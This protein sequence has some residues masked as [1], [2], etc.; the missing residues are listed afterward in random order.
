MRQK[1]YVWAISS[2]NGQAKIRNFYDTI[3]GFLTKA[4][5]N[6]QPASQEIIQR[7]FNEIFALPEEHQGYMVNNQQI[8]FKTNKFL[9]SNFKEDGSLNNEC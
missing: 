2:P 7:L 6:G 1:I 4:G 8:N 3:H 9:V 5:L